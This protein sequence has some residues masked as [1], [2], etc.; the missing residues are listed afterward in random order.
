MN[1][2]Y[3]TVGSI[4]A[5]IGILLGAIGAHWLRSNLS[6]TDLQ[7]FETGVRYQIYHALIIIIL[8]VING[9]LNKKLLRFS[10]HAFWVGIILFSGSIYLLSTSS[11]SGL[12]LSWL[13]PATPVGGVLFI[14][15]WTGI[16]IAALSN[17]K[18]D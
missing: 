12:Q 13:G 6:L 1:N 15:G 2:N 5:A 9:R 17:I 3:I 8:G 10:F 14:A 4:F 7:N 11:F 16:I 18:E